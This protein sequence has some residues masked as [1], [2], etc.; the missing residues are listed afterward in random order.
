MTP[1][2]P[3]IDA[4]KAAPA[5]CGER[6]LAG[7]YGSNALIFYHP[8]AEAEALAPHWAALC[9]ELEARGIAVAAGIAGHPFLQFRKTE[10]PECALKA[11]EYAQL[12]PA[13]HVGVCNS[14][15]L[16]I[17]ADKRYSLGDVFGAIEEYKLA[18]LGRSGKRP[19]L[20][21]S[22]NLLCGAGAA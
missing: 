14:L 6:V 19:C 12:L 10:A 20:E 18:L 22:G 17:S 1:L 3:L 7:Q 9:T 21:F 16:N 4:W 13:P 15:A 8:G 11:L 2:A 5:L